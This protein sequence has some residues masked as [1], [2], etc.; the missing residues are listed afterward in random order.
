[1]SDTID[2]AAL[3]AA[4]RKKGIWDMV[5]PA[6]TLLALLEERKRLRS[7]LDRIGYN[8]DGSPGVG[9]SKCVRIARAALAGEKEPKT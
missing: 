7:A 9:L 4:A 2:H 1:M 3:E 8:R 6:E 5:V